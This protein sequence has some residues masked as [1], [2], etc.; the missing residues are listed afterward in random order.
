MIMVDSAGSTE[1]GMGASQRARCGTLL[2]TGWRGSLEVCSSS[3]TEEPH[4][5]IVQPL[6][7]RLPDG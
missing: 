4:T 1:N 3:T 7:V 6:L 2:S 5:A